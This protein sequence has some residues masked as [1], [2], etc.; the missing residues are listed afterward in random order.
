MG[1]RIGIDARLAG[2][3][4]AGIGRYVEELLRALLAE[5][6][7]H[8]WI[9]FLEKAKQLPWLVASDRVK[10]VIVPIR[11]YTLREQFAMPS[12]FA[13]ERLDLLH[14][15][16]FN[17][18]LLYRGKFVVTIHDL[19][20]HEM[21]DPRATTLS[22]SMYLLKYHA[23]RLVAEHAMKS[24]QIVVVPSEH[25]KT[26]VE[27]FPHRRID[28]VFNGLSTA[29]FKDNAAKSKYVP[30]HPYLLCVGSLYPHKNL[31]LVLD[32]LKELQGTDLV[33]VSG[34]SIF[35]NEFLRDVEQHGLR[36]RV[37]LLGH[38]TDE[39]IVSLYK[40]SIALVFPSRSEGFG[41]PGIE[42]MAAGAPVLA[43]DIPVFREIYQHAAKFF[44][45]HSSKSLADAVTAVRH[46][47]QLRKTLQQ[48]GRVVASTYTWKNTARRMLKI[49]E[50]A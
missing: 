42:A 13:R 4:N 17:V 15:P 40:G 9:I 45:P 26:I 37:H 1:M 23:Y 46:E 6:S 3:E 24:A 28:V 32:A 34:R 12:V 48:N 33:L 2:T 8:T 20:W 11:H 39:D 50:S 5:P 47:G 29:F 16:H 31:T 21:R 7:A 10:L 38:L 36:D 14:V 27:K 22:P 44:D 19:L 25:V 18:P 41:L 43:S 49:Y 35:T 30:S